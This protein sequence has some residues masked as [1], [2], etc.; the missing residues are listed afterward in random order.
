LCVPA[1]GVP[2]PVDAARGVAEQAATSSAIPATANAVLRWGK[3]S[4]LS[5]T[6]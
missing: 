3:A 5:S 1:V 6:G 4:S 2:A